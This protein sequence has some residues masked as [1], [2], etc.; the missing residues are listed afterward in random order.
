MLGDANRGFAQACRDGRLSLTDALTRIEARATELADQRRNTDL[1]ALRR[2][3]NPRA[4]KQVQ[5][6]SGANASVSPVDNPSLPELFALAID[7]GLVDVSEE[8]AISASLNPFAFVTL[9][10]PD[11]ADHE[12]DYQ[13]YSWLR[14]LDG[15]VTLGGQGDAFDRDGDGEVDEALR[16]QSLS[17]S[18]AW[19]VRARVIGS[20]DRRDKGFVDRYSTKV[21]P[22]LEA[23]LSAYRK[24]L[25]SSFTPKLM[26][27]ADDSA[28][29]EPAALE[30]LLAD[31]ELASELANVGGRSKETLEVIDGLVK[32]VDRSLVVT[33]FASGTR[34]ED[35]LGPDK[36][37]FGL[38]AGWGRGLLDHTLN[39]DWTK[40]EGL[41]G[42]PDARVTKVGYQASGEI[43]GAGFEG[44]R[45]SFF[46]AFEHYSNV[47]AAKHRTVAMAGGKLEVRLADG[48]TLPLSVTW[49]NHRDL[50]TDADDIVGNVAIALDLSD[51]R[52]AKKAAPVE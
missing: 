40:L 25:T 42:A 32:D 17:D 43:Q 48:L 13:A 3:P 46:G 1:A 27:A 38:R 35:E 45:L 37:G 7:N 47:P 20:R 10:R 23:E 5:A 14:R 33:V 16:A 8:H 6:S 15:K 41:Q 31:P 11:V 19:E 12:K 49:A 28:C 18:V 2:Q 26:Q 22:F 9:V 39:V 24:F 29:I 21:K 4:A 50:L 36:T 51:L 30:K 52:K 44:S 34:R